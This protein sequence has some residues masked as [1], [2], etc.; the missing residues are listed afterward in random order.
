MRALPTGA[1]VLVP[2]SI[3]TQ[4]NNAVDE[5]SR[6][7]ETDYAR[8]KLTSDD[9][10][11]YGVNNDYDPTAARAKVSSLVGRLEEEH[12]FGS[13]EPVAGSPVVVTVNQNQQVTVSVTPIQEI[14]NSSDDDEIKAQLQ[15]LKNTLETSKDAKKLSRILNTIQERSWEVFIKVLPYVLEHWGSHPHH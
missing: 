13:S 3:G 5:L 2:R 15:E 14:I 7:A 12:G 10:W 8:L 1:N 4:Y 9:E 11:E 6:V